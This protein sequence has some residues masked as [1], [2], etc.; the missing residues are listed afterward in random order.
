MEKRRK[1]LFPKLALTLG[2]AIVCSALVSTVGTHRMYQAQTEPIQ[3]TMLAHFARHERWVAWNSTSSDISLCFVTAEFSETANDADRLPIFEPSMIRHP[4]RHFFF[5]ICLPCRSDMVGKL[6]IC[7]I[8]PIYDEL[9]NH[10]GPSFWDG[11][12]N[13]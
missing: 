10:D 12:M 5:P 1:A 8:F 2:F 13:P 7:P 9:R 11:N 4:P 6:W 3:H